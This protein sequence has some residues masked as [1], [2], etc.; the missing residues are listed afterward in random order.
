MSPR[1]KCGSP[2]SLANMR[3]AELG[4]GHGQCHFLCTDRFSPPRRAASSTLY[5]TTCIGTGRITGPHAFQ[6]P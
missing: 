6:N 1:E 5:I 3:T 2:L 4:L